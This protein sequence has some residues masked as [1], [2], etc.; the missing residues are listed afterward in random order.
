MPVQPIGCRRFA[1]FGSLLLLCAML[2]GQ[3]AFSTSPNQQDFFQSGGVP[4]WPILFPVAVWFVLSVAAFTA[5]VVVLVRPMKM[6]LPKR[7]CLCLAPFFL[8]IAGFAV[9]FNDMAAYH[10]VV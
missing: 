8:C 7:V 1:Y 10:S 2:A 5:M 9:A 6:R 3:I 4:E